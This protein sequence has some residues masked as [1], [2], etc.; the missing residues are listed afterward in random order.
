MESVERLPFS[1]DERCKGFIPCSIILP[2]RILMLFAPNDQ[3]YQAANDVQSDD[4]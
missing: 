2:N 1:F 4:W 3:S